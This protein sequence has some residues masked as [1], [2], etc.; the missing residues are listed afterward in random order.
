MAGLGEGEGGGGGI[1]DVVERG[2]ERMNRK[3]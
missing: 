2:V 1:V 3:K